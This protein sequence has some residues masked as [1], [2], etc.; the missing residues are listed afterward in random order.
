MNILEA[1]DTIKGLPDDYL[2]NEA[3]YPSGKLPQFLVV[4]EIQRRQDM[5]QRYQANAQQPEGTVKDQIL[6]GAQQGAQQAPQAAQQ[7]PQAMPPQPMP[8]GIPQTIQP[9]GTAYMASGGI[10]PGGTVYMADG[11]KVPESSWWEKYF[12][13]PY[14]ESMIGRPPRERPEPR[15]APRISPK[16]WIAP[17]DQEDLEREI[18]A[19][20]GGL[21]DTA[22]FRALGLADFLS[23]DDEFPTNIHRYRDARRRV[24]ESD[25][26]LLN[27]INAA[28]QEHRNK[29]ANQANI[30]EV[31]DTLLTGTPT[32]AQLALVRGRP[33]YGNVEGVSPLRP[34]FQTGTTPTDTGATPTD[35]GGGIASLFN[36]EDMAKPSQKEKAYEEYMSKMLEEGLPEPVDISSYKDAALKRSEEAVANARQM[37]LAETLTNLGAGVMRGDPASGLS[38]A[39]KAALDAL[40]GGRE[41]SITEK[42]SAEQIALQQ[43]NQERQQKIEE[44]GFKEKGLGALAKGERERIN[45]SVEAAL[46]REYYS[47]ARAQIAA[48]SSSNPMVAYRKAIQDLPM[49][50]EEALA[51]AMSSDLGTNW[52]NEVK[53]LWKQKFIKDQMTFIN[54][55]YGIDERHYDDM[56]E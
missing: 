22:P 4:S 13:G 36:Y 30:N 27:T 33:A 28:R 12:V 49:K 25:Q 2:F 23:V 37:A 46:K 16:L 51:K 19:T 7:A 9:S 11:R 39:S 26:R 40:R 45:S 47:I 24:E 21:E 52:T 32:D 55:L 8:Q 3:Q 41:E 54:S 56:R 29:L 35:V 42:R 44:M 20:G 43:A 53:M 50:A 34:D 14:A 48:S 5:R 31:T 17:S 10:A 6:M 38:D 15:P 18:G 1:E